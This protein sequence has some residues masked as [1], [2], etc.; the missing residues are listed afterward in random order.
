[1]EE[2]GANINGARLED[3]GTPLYA[4][5]QIGN[6][7][8]VQFLVKELGADINQTAVNGA[9]PVFIAAQNDHVAVVRCLVKELGADVNQAADDGTTPLLIAA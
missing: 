2:L 9:T 4:A 6:L 7:V 3:G 8:Y 1:V 5:A